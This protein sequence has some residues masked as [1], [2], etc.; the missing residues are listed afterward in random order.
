M[1]VRSFGVLCFRSRVQ[2]AG[3][4]FSCFHF[5]TFSILIIRSFSFSFGGF[6]AFIVMCGADFSMHQWAWL[7]RLAKLG[8]ICMRIVA[9]GGDSGVL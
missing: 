2:G 3:G 6:L 9:A 8:F 1:L 5:I 7:Q 4:G